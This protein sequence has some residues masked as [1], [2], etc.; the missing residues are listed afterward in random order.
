MSKSMTKAD[1]ANLSKEQRT[2]LVQERRDEAVDAVKSGNMP[3]G[4][5]ISVCGQ[6][7]VATPSGTTDRG[8]VSYRV[9]RS[10]FPSPLTGYDAM[11]QAF[12]ITLI[13]HDAGGNFDGGS[14]VI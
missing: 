6:E 3:K 9:G 1:W 13:P 5:R 4:I 10:R 12:V 11:T 8:S 2:A 14:D 7:L